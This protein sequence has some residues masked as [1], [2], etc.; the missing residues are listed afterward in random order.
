[1][2]KLKSGAEKLGF[3][4]NPE[5]LELFEIF[6]REILD[7]NHRVNLTAIT[8]YE[9]IQ[10]KHFLDSLTL[11]PVLDDY[12]SGENLRLLDIG[13]GAG[14][15]GIPL[16]II[17]PDIE[18]S[19][20]EAT[21]KKVEFLQYIVSMLGLKN[22]EILNGR[23]EDIARIAKYREH[24]SVVISRAVAPLAVLAELGLPFCFGGGIC[25]F[26]KKGD[27]KQE[28]EQSIN[29][30]EIL[31]GRLREIKRISLEELD[32]NRHLVIIDKVKTTP[33]KYPRRP[34]IPEK[35]PVK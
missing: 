21:S 5:Q 24:F 31:G 11:V 28:I 9:E 20:L 3:S 35:R 27:I 26:P 1:M 14:L 23:A 4:L 10:I 2:D 18:L 19:L 15:P 25:I 16:K 33:D 30:I 22:V 8:E 7:W 34:G 13:T 32:D 17:L 12:Q 6:Y 29:A